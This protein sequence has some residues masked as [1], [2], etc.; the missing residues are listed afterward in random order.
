[1]VRD[2]EIE[3][4]NNEGGT[5]WKANAERVAVIFKPVTRRLLD[6]ARPQ[7]GQRVLEVGCGTGPTIGALA[8]RVGPDG[9]VV[10]LDVSRM[11]LDVAQTANAS[12]S[13][14]EFLLADAQ[15]HDFGS[16]R[17]D[18]IVSQFGVMFFEEPMQSF[19]NLR[20]ALTPAGRVV[21]ACWR[22]I[23]ANPF[24]FVP[25]NAAKP[26]APPQPPN[27]SDGPGP[28]AFAERARLERILLDSG[29]SEI[30][31]VQHDESVVVDA[32][33]DAEA[34]ARRMTG[35]G[36]TAWLLSEVDEETKSKAAAAI[37]EAF[38][39]YIGPDGLRLG[40][41]IWLVSASAISV[42]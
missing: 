25:V 35:F 31:I 4:W 22:D 18:L 20:R 14:I 1:M 38:R 26:F 33:C 13:N 36:P 17:F 6:L 39:P 16:E 32:S 7:L 9:T 34:A 23:S 30:E 12:R 41:G 8:D 15:T 28:F 11:L 42:V 10:A 29:F 19:R 3:Y 21:F 27:D 37:A 2:D 5:R 40:A 24:F